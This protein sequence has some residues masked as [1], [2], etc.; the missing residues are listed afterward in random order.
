MTLL[1]WTAVLRS[2]ST[3]AVCGIL[4][5]K[6]CLE[7][8]Q[9]WLLSLSRCSPC[10]Y[11][12]PV[13]AT[14]SSPL[15]LPPTKMMNDDLCQCV[16]GGGLI[17]CVSRERVW[18]VLGSNKNNKRARVWVFF[19]RTEAEGTVYF[20]FSQPKTQVNLKP[21]TNNRQPSPSAA[22]LNWSKGS[23]SPPYYPLFL[24]FQHGLR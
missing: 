13:V 8:L 19:F 5:K 1:F 14:A 10:R 16:F 6:D 3:P 9:R 15:W 17:I 11:R 12:L 24:F 18:Y 22:L 21:P 20:L 2:R 23:R 4:W 7:F